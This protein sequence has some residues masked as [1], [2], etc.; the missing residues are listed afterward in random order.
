LNFFVCQNF[1]KKFFWVVAQR[2]EGMCAKITGANFFRG[3]LS[4]AGSSDPWWPPP[5]ILIRRGPIY[6]AFELYAKLHNVH[7]GKS[8]RI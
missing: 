7:Y 2:S 3:G 1:S 6:I 8:K 4:A 5:S